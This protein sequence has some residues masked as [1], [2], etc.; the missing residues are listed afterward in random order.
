MPFTA[1]DVLSR[2]SSILQDSGFVRWTLPELRNWLNDGLREIAVLKPTAVNK[3]VELPL[4][5]GTYQVL[6]AQYFTLVQAVRNL[7][8]LDAS[9]SKRGGGNTITV[10]KRSSLD[11][12][13]PGWQDEAKMP[14]SK[15]VAHVI[16]NEFDESGF[17]VAPGNDGTGIIEAI[18]G[19]Y[20]TPVAAPAN[21]LSI[22]SY[23]ATVDLR[24]IYQNALVDFIL[25][26]AYSKDMAQAGAA[27]R[28]VAHYNQFANSL[29][30]KAQ[31]DAMNNVNTSAATS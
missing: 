27:Q 17:Y 23:T 7:I 22:E 2:A 11:T 19:A 21:P 15:L 9:P 26:R 14:Y 4:Q 3:T 31:A 16:D 28:S 29:G 25:Y 24:D 30:L 18:V 10:V 6:P 12:T 13:I 20:P 1:Q 5:K 8:T